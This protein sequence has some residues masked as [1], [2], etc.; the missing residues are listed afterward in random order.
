MGSTGELTPPTGSDEVG[1]VSAEIRLEQTAA[2]V[3]AERK[4]IAQALHDTVSQTLTGT[5]LQAVLIAR[6]L[7]GNG[8]E[9]ADDV[10]R[11]TEM[12]HQAVVELQGVVRLL[13][14]ESKSD[15]AT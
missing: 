4:R 3:Q 15:T 14:P 13:Q 5:Y 7:E 1:I 11:L 2:A 8:S 10:A 6:K 12:I 9:A